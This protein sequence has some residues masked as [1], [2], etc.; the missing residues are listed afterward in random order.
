MD[1]SRTFRSG[2]ILCEA[3]AVRGHGVGWITAV[4]HSPAFGHWI[5]LGFARGGAGG[6]ERRTLVAADP[7]RRE[8]VKV[9]IVSPHM[10]DAKGERLHG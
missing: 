3:G 4:T 8:R 2:A 5:G 6:G 9:E 7:V 1:R 10:F